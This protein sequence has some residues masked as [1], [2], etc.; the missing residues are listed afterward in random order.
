MRP[1]KAIAEIPNVTMIPPKK[2][3]PL[4]LLVD[5]FEDSTIGLAGLA[6]GWFFC[7]VSAV[8]SLDAIV[9]NL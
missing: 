6:V 3:H 1:T 7:V 8:F 4:K 5:L 9:V 2:R